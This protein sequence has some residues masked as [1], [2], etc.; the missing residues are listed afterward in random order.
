MNLTEL[1]N[2]VYIE[3]NRPDLVDQTQQAVLATTHKLHTC[4]FFFRDIDPFLCNFSV[5]A[6]IQALDTSGIPLYRSIGYVRKYEPSLNAYELNPTLLPPLLNTQF[7][8]I[9]PRC[10]RDFIKI[11]TP[12]DIFDDYDYER[13]DVAYQAG[14]NLFIKSRA[15]FQYLLM[16]I[17]KF[18]NITVDNYKSWI[19]ELWPYAIIY[20]ATY[21]VFSQI[22]DL[23]SANRYKSNNNQT[24]LAIEQL[25]TLKM[26][27]IVAEGY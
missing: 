7:G 16:G 4:D 12:T 24:G 13:S 8:N 3:T 17:Y 23:E 22:G 1:I 9:D 27:N 15:A 26:S 25:N 2:G 19:A 6:Y 14:N 5:S 20:D 11:I 10:L 21:S 18:P